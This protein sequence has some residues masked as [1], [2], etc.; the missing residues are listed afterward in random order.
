MLDYIYQWIENLAFYLVIIVAVIQMVPG[1]NYKKYIRF[2]AGMILILMLAGPVFKVFGAW[3]FH[4]Q[5]YH[6]ELERIEDATTYLEN[7]I[8]EEDVLGIH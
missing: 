3:E 2:F 1:E 6:K 4:N 7:M 5:E 8:G